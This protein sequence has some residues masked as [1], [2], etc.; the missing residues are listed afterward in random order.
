MPFCW[1]T[2]TTPTHASDEH[3]LKTG[4]R[5]DPQFYAYFIFFQKFGSVR[6]E[7]DPQQYKLSTPPLL[8]FF[9]H[10][11]A[12]GVA[13][14]LSTLAL[15]VFGGYKSNACCVVRL[16]VVVVSVSHTQ[17]ARLYF[18]LPDP[19]TLAA[20]DAQV[21]LIAGACTTA[22]AFVCASPQPLTWSHGSP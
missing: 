11:A 6:L 5:N 21:P 7:S 2:H 20:R 15:D 22:V 12:Q 4:K 13:V 10:L 3:E 1:L 18:P 8:L 14:A 9:F 16:R 17:L 19:A